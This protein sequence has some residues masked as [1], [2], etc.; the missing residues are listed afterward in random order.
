MG[1]EQAGTAPVPVPSTFLLFGSGMLVVIVY[2]WR[3]ERAQQA[4]YKRKEGFLYQEPHIVGCGALVFVR[5]GP[6]TQRPP[7]RSPW[8][9]SCFIP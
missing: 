7:R 6:N 3:R 8:G 2:V 9:L 4:Y 5:D 1:I